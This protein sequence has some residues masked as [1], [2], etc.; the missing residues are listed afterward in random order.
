MLPYL[1][2]CPFASW[3]EVC[4]QTCCA[5]SYLQSRHS[6]TRIH[7]RNAGSCEFKRRA[8]V[9]AAA[10]HLGCDPGLRNGGLDAAAAGPL[11][12]VAITCG[13]RRDSRPGR[14]NQPGRA[15]LSQT[16]PVSSDRGGNWDTRRLFTAVVDAPK[17][18]IGAS[19]AGGEPAEPTLTRPYFNHGAAFS[20]RQISWTGCR[21]RTTAA[22]FPLTMTSAARQRVL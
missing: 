11:A 14:V 1:C 21:S 8:P 18:A 4:S 17:L 16:A 20:P 7:H 13:R 2:S 12:G 22:R 5:E 3:R 10:N 9:W 19:Y 6:Q 15:P